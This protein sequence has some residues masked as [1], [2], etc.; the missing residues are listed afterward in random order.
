[1]ATLVV[2]PSKAFA[3]TTVPLD[4]AVMG[5]TVSPPVRS[6]EVISINAPPPI[7]E[8]QTASAPGRIGLSKLGV[9]K[10]YPLYSISAKSLSRGMIEVFLDSKK[11]MLSLFRSFP[12]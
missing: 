4:P 1:L 11:H 5:T 10:L 3:H 8:E 2:K 7:Y 12:M 9:I 6:K